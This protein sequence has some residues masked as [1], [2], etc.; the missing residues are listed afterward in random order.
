V[1]LLAPFVTHLPDGSARTGQAEAVIQGA[2][3]PW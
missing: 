2:P 3:L 1:T